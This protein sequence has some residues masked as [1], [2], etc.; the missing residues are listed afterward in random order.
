VLVLLNAHKARDRLHYEGFRHFHEC[1]YRVV[2]A[3]SVTPWA[4]RAMDRALAPVVVAAARHL[5]PALTP[6]TD[7]G[8]IA[9]YKTARAEILKMMLDRAP[10]AD[11]CGGH[12]ALRDAVERLM[13]AWE[14]LANDKRANAEPLYYGYPREKALLHDPL[15]PLLGTLHPDYRKFTAGRSMRDVE[16]ASVL[17]VTDPYGQ[18]L[19]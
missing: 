18:S 17:K 1:F 16:H 19:G 7:A 10:A 4:A 6:D 15:D 13:D 9:D 11:V 5:I 12:A 3:T 14:A 8:D 2:E